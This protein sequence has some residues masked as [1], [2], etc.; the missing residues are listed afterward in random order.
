MA[1]LPIRLY[2]DPVLRVKC[3][4]VELYDSDLAT[5]AHDM[6]QTMYD[7]P[8]V[9]LAA[10]QVGIEL[11]LAVVDLTGGEDPQGL[12]ILV[13]PE[14][15]EPEGSES[16]VEGCLSIPGLTDRVDRPASIAV[17]A[18]SLE[19]EPIAFRAGGWLARAVCHEVDHLDGILFVD[20][21]RGLRKE[22]A[23]RQLKRFVSEHAPVAERAAERGS[24]G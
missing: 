15:G 21:L 7:A 1:V 2:P 9:G 19:G 22:R 16:E 12:L 18:R 23:R 3:P 8:G 24:G 5:L 20:R 10:P 4:A 14:I 13:N 17:R 11:R 6:V